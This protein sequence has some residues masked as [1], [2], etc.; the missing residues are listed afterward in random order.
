MYQAPALDSSSE[1]LQEV[2][3]S[4]WSKVSIMFKHSRHPI[5]VERE[6]QS[7]LPGQLLIA[8][9][10]DLIPHTLQAEP[11]TPHLFHFNCQFP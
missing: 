2:H 8:E 7:S 6:S 1:L 4:L 11:E 5:D 9:P 10:K 3:R